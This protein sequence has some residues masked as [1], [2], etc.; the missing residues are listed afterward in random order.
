MNNKV[1]NRYQ[2]SVKKQEGQIYSSSNEPRETPIEKSGKNISKIKKGG[3]NDSIDELIS[4]MVMPNYNNIEISITDNV[5]INSDHNQ[6]KSNSKIPHR[7]FSNI[8][9]AN[10]LNK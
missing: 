8:R 9:A 2:E 5:A 4:D 6:K 3:L 1:N 10:I 7:E